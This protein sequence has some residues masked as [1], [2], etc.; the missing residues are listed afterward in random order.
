LVLNILCVT[1]FQGRK[2]LRGKVRYGYNIWRDGNRKKLYTKF[3]LKYG[4][5]VEFIVRRHNG[6]LPCITYIQWRI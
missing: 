2:I 1:L 6:S 3:H 4:L 5:R